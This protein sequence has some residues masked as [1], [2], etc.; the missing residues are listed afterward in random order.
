MEIILTIAVIIVLCILLNISADLII[1]GIIILCALL[2]GTMAI[3]FTYSMLLMLT[4]KKQKASFVKFD[5]NPK[6]K[7]TSAYYRIS[8]RELPC[9][10]PCEPGFLKKI[11]ASDKHC[12]V[13]CNL[14]KGFVYDKFAAVTT[15]FGLIFSYLAV[16]AVCFLKSVI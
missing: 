1:M 3:F 6:G 4:A 11:Y 10:F 9:I 12:T 2:I 13:R 14:K 5:K 15:V 7:Y 8:E 16:I